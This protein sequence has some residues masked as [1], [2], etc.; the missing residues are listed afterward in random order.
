MLTPVV[1]PPGRLSLAASPSRTGS[2]PMVETVGIL[3]VA[4][5]AATADGS[6]PTDTNTV[7]AEQ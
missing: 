5:L 3:E 1:L 2:V 4:A 7:L 6:P